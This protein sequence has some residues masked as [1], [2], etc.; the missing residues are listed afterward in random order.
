M[1]K[2]LLKAILSELKHQRKN[3]DDALWSTDDIA[4]HLTTSKSTV[5][6]R[7]I[8]KRGFPRAVKI[9]NGPRRWYAGE[10]KSFLKKQREAC[11]P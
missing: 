7:I 3:R 9:E 1:E 11:R 6:S 2:E 5:H 4:E 8:S 10:V